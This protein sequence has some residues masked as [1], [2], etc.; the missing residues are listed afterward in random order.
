VLRA[1]VVVGA[2]V[3]AVVLL[4]K[5]VGALLQLLAFLLVVGLI[6]VGAWLLLARA[7]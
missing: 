1:L 2:A 7:R 5:L 6:A 4:V 3:L